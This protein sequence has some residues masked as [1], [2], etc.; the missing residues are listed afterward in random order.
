MI[1][2]NIQQLV[3]Q[4]RN[5]PEEL[6]L[7]K[8]IWSWKNENV[9]QII[10]YSTWI[11]RL[12]RAWCFEPRPGLLLNN[13]LLPFV[14]PIPLMDPSLCFE[15]RAPLPSNKGVKCFL[16]SYSSFNWSFNWWFLEKHQRHDNFYVSS[17]K[18][19][20]IEASEST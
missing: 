6:L 20:Q 18:S 3:K 13:K 2:L 12:H 7:L 10:V 5:I 9:E 16:K 11:W 4:S 15:A 19:R 1:S 14:A 8:S 17:K